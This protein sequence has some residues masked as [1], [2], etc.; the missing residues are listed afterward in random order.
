ME[1]KVGVGGN[2]MT[3]YFCDALPEMKKDYD[4]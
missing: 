2:T 3:D 4:R 1:R